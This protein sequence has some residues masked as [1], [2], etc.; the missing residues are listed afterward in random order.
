ML[1]VREAVPAAYRRRQHAMRRNAEAAA[2]GGGR[3]PLNAPQ[4]P[5]PPLPPLKLGRTAAAVKLR[6]AHGQKGR[7]PHA[8]G[9]V[10]G[11]G[12]GPG[13]RLPAL[14]HA[15]PEAAVTLAVAAAAAAV[16]R[17]RA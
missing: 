5:H 14:P 13:T 4:S 1:H 3:R 8:L 17:A 12:H 16:R 6:P 7:G 11:S 10:L 9:H 2:A 15:R